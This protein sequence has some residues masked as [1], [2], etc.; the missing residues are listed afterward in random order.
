MAAWDVQVSVWLKQS[1][2]D[3][4]GNAVEQALHSLGHD[5][6][7]RVRIG[8]HMSLR[9]TADTQ[10]EAESKVTQICETVLCNPVMETFTYEIRAIDVEALV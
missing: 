6:V 4:Q 3:P 8:K 9:V 10:D 1:V 5:G 2:F 7:D